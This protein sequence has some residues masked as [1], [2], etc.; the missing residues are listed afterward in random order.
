MFA[1]DGDS[2]R[3]T[4]IEDYQ[5]TCTEFINDISKDY[6]DWV[7]RYELPTEEEDKR[8]NAIDFIVKT[9]NE[10]IYQYGDSIK[11]VDIIMNDG[12]SKMA[13]STAGYPFNIEIFASNQSRYV[14][15][16]MKPI[17]LSLKAY[18]RNNRQ[19]KLTNYDKDNTF[20]LSSASPVDVSY[21]DKSF[22]LSDYL[23]EY[24]ILKPKNLGFQDAISITIKIDEVE[25]NAVMESRGYTTL[26]IMK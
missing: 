22:E 6:K 4:S 12:I 2:E 23:D 1:S 26:I 7:D 18:P 16:D 3:A 17:K 19:V 21:T 11:K 8:K 13:E 25:N 15:H 9:T 5:Y 14:M 20:L 10:F 24:V